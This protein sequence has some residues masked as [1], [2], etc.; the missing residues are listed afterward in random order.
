MNHIA[1]A[2]SRLSSM[3]KRVGAAVIKNGKVL[4]V[5][6]NRTGYTTRTPKAWSRHAEVQAV[7]QAGNVRGSTVYVYRGH[8]LTDSPLLARPCTTCME[9]LSIAGV[10]K[11]VYSSPKGWMQEKV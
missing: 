7:I 8:R 11:V 10:R 4:G 3:P 2:A 6:Y 1:E 5:G 9:L